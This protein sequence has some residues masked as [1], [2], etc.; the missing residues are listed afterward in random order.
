MVS[1]PP[2]SEK[3]SA[4][5]ILDRLLAY[6]SSPWKAAVVI[7]AAIVCGAGWLIWTERVRIA[8]AVLHNANERVELNEAGFIA[9]APM[10]L[11]NTRADFAMLVQID[12]NDN[13]LIDKIGVDADGNRWVPTTGPQQALMVSSS[14]PRLVKFLNN[15]VVCTDIEAASFEDAK[16][17]AAKGY[18]RACL[19][20][21]PPIL[22]VEV[23]GLIVAWKQ[24]PAPAAEQRADLAMKSAA[25]KYASW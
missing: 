16:A 14:M 1:E 12:L 19:V 11:R 18:A 24:A 25:L 4:A 15:E 22:G 2:A 9:D 21:V 3:L 17:L 7:I 20:S 23:G 6:A 8:D 5:G 10:L 13:L